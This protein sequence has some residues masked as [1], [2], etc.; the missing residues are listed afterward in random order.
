MNLDNYIAN[1]KGENNALTMP[2]SIT[3]I[4]FGHIEYHEILLFDRN[5]ELM[6][7]TINENCIEKKKY[8]RQYLM[9]LILLFCSTKSFS[10]IIYLLI[11]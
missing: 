5:Q 3:H 8:T 2:M 4:N 11:I 9:F 1:N 6:N 7:I 10:Q